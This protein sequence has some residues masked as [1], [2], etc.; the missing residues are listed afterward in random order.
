MGG[1]V[2]LTIG[3]IFGSYS[4]LRGGAGPR[5]FLATLSQYMLGSAASFAFFLSIGSI[6]RTEDRIP[7]ALQ[8]A[9]M[10]LLPPNIAAQPQGAAYATMRARWMMEKQRQL[11]EVESRKIDVFFASTVFG[12]NIFDTR[13]SC[14]P[15]AL[16]MTSQE[17]NVSNT[18]DE[19]LP[20][21]SIAAPPNS[22]NGSTNTSGG[23]RLAGVL[24]GMGSGLTKTAVGHGFDTIKTRLQCSPPG[25]YV[26]ALD[27]LMK[28]VRNEGASPPAI[29]WAISDSIL[30]GS[31]YNYRLWLLKN[32]GLGIVERTPLQDSGG[33]NAKEFRLTVLG[34][35]LAGLGAG[36][37][38]SFISH[39]VE[40]LKVNLQLQ[41]ERKVADR[42]FKGPIDVFRQVIKH[43]GF[44]GM[45][46]GFGTTLYFRGCFFWMFGSVEAYMRLAGVLHG[47]MFEM[48]NATATFFAGGL[49]AFSF[50]AFAIPMD[51]VKNRIMAW[52]LTEQ[53]PSVAAVART[54]YRT[55]GWRG[56]YAGFTPI[57]L[58][59]FPVNAAAYS[60]YEGI[61]RLLGAE[62]IRGANRL[63]MRA[64]LVIID[65]GKNGHAAQLLGS[66]SA[67][68]TYK[69]C[70]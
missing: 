33:D 23:I 41:R 5:G 29:G 47:T 62:K 1:G 16:S 49:A 42:K 58:R 65:P 7:I 35:G 17:Q 51:N 14:A 28:T 9:Q 3:F 11:S 53:R 54:I 43:R 32:G 37:T 66:S 21:S 60:V 57:I 18:T 59:A 15:A 12:L 55:H 67:S 27:C 48:S 30:M 63:V 22:A 19:P 2:G 56:F 34:H 64:L 69:H 61:M 20:T 6:I 46:R 45:Y 68:T 70:A 10:H 25:T 38:S 50:W 13:E 31:L 39:P 26:G 24:A 52:P 44:F 40:L 4:I 36:W 8:A